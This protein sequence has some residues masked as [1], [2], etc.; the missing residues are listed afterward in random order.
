MSI[1]SEKFDVIVIGGGPAGLMAAGHAAEQGLRVLLLEKNKKLGEKLKITGG[2]RCNITNAEFD[3]HELLSHYRKA[4][5]FLYSPFSQFGVQDTFDFFESRGLPIVVQARKRAF[6]ETENAADVFRVLEA[7]IKKNNVTIKTSSTVTKIKAN[8]AKNAIEYV[9]T[10]KERYSADSYIL[11][12][13]G[14]SHPETGSTGDGFRW[15]K[16]LG[17]T[18][19][20]PNPNIV[21]LKVKE[22]WVKNI[23]GVSLSFMKITFFLNEKKAFS[24][25]GKVLFTH[26]GL[27]GPL[28]LNSAY[29]VIELLDKGAVTCEIDLF[30]D[31]DKGTL[32]KRIINSFEKNKN[33]LL[34]NVLKELAPQGMYEIIFQLLDIKEDEKFVHSVTVE[35]RKK[36]ITLFKHLPLT[37][38]GTMGYEWAVVSDGGVS[39]EEVDMK[40]MQS[41]IYPNLYF[42]GD[43]LNITRPSGG[44]SLQLCWTTGFV[45]GNAVGMKS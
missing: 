23:S 11:A 10:G 21:P 27:S 37:I 42:T 17:H 44:Y 34:K 26:F 40:T 5:P 19:T 12:T 18:V 29:D 31:T 3:I 35:E 41:K 1:H 16:D 4:K 7:F 9:E 25:T 45:A 15:L 43:I 28:I 20:D 8:A 33:K 38:S 13:G 14:L 2:G 24:K 39:L 6:P 30:P 32:E 22:S 36:L